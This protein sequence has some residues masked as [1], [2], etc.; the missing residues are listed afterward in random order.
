MGRELCCWL[1]D[2]LTYHLL[3]IYRFQCQSREVHCSRYGILLPHETPWMTP[4]HSILTQEL[5]ECLHSSASDQLILPRGWSGIA[6]ANACDKTGC[7]HLK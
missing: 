3:R 4:F 2:F 5:L 1:A 6:L 7:S